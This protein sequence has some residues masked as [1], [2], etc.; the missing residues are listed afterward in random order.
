MRLENI[1]RKRKAMQKFLKNDIAE[2]LR[3]GRD[4]NAYE[5]VIYLSSI[6]ILLFLMLS[7][8]IMHNPNLEN[9]AHVQNPHMKTGFLLKSV[10]S[11][12]RKPQYAEAQ[13]ILYAKLVP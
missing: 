7:F 3:C 10:R 5:R 6:I 9:L 4:Y 12:S 1:Q 11:F 8:L 2:L 13:I